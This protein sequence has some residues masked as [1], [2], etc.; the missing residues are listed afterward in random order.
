MGAYYSGYVKA[1]DY[2]QNSDGTFTCTLKTLKDKNPKLPPEDK[3]IMCIGILNVNNLKSPNNPDQMVIMSD[4]NKYIFIPLTKLDD[5]QPKYLILYLF[6]ITSAVV[7]YNITIPNCLDYIAVQ[8]S[9][10][11]SNYVPNDIT[12][13]NLPDKS[14]DKWNYRGYLFCQNPPNNLLSI[15]SNK[16]AWTDIGYMYKVLYDNKIGIN[17]I[18]PNTFCVKVDSPSVIPALNDSDCRS[19]KTTASPTI[20]ASSVNYGSNS[21]M[22][23][24]IVVCVLCCLSMC[25]SSIFVMMRRKK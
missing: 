10:S 5:D 13:N 17:N 14:G 2:K 6:V 11:D 7:N 3:S 24:G 23:V 9:L 19:I 12:Y 18:G 22:M 21:G 4:D 25:G 16:S 15:N 1:A 8:I 20:T